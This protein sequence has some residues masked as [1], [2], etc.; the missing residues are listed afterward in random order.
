VFDSFYPTG[1]M[2]CYGHVSLTNCHAVS[3]IQ[4]IAAQVYATVQIPAPICGSLE[5]KE[6]W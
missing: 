3:N 1:V 6:V 4:L 2:S 5:R